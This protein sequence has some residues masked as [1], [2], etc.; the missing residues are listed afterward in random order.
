MN[1]RGIARGKFR[2]D[3]GRAWKP[4]ARR[5]MIERSDAK[6]TAAAEARRRM[7]E[8]GASARPEEKHTA[9]E[10][11]RRMIARDERA[12]ARTAAEARR[13]MIERA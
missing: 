6:P 11:R 5:R 13:R 8:R 2:M 12:A 9:A 7:I 10:A 3:G 4:E 1:K